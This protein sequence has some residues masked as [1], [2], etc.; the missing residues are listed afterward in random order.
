MREERNES[1]TTSGFLLTL[2]GIEGSGKS[3]VGKSI[4]EWLQEKNRPC[5]F[6]RE[7]GGTPVGES[8][9]NWLLNA[10]VAL[11]PETELFLFEAARAQLMRETILP[12]LAGGKTVIS[13]RFIDS[14]TAYQGYGRGLDLELI[15]RL[16]PTACYGR[17]PDL[18][19]LLDV[20]VA[21]GLER[22]RR[23]GLPDG[24]RDRFESESHEF[25]QKVR[26]GF[27]RIAALEPS[28]VVV[29]P[30][31]GNADVVWR[32]VKKILEQRLPI[33]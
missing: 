2:E 9:R 25:M 12:A 21:V 30:V 32:E 19:L 22:A 17:M 20:E 6:T 15:R 13:D 14:T 5:V 26:Q 11:T 18:T 33:E 7:P 4:A 23:V 29:V 3:T 28:R 27:L 1:M 10:A 24:N 16:N 8:I 31:V